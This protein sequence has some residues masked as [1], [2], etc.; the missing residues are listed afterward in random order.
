MYPQDELDKALRDANAPMNKARLIV[1]RHHNEY[2]NM[3]PVE[4]NEVYVV[5]F[6]RIGEDWLALVST[7]LDDGIYYSVSY[8]SE[9]KHTHLEVFSKVHDEMFIY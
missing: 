6:T 3:R 2:G 4:L 8:S 5:T 7:T 9:T 1:Q